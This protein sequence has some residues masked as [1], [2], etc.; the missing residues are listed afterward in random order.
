LPHLRH[1]GSSSDRDQSGGIMDVGEVPGPTI[2]RRSE[3][4]PRRY[5][6]MIGGGNASGGMLSEAQASDC[7]LPARVM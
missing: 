1:V 5:M 7:K 4:F 2:L 6:W 3:N